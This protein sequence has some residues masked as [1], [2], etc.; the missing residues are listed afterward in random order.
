MHKPLISQKTNLY[1]PLYGAFFM[2][3]QK[4]NS[5]IGCLAE[6]PCK[7]RSALSGNSWRVG[8]IVLCQGSSSSKS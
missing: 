1:K 3:D 8:L 5:N 2:S 4:R 6:R 7:Y